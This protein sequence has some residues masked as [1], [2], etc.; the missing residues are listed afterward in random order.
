M[1]ERNAPDPEAAHPEDAGP[2]AGVLD[3]GVLDAGVRRV[4]ILTVSALAVLIAPPLYLLLDLAVVGRLGGDELAALAVA[5]LVLS[6]IST[7]L[8]FLSYGTTARSARR[9]GAGDRPGAIA[10]G[11]QASWIAVAVG[12]VIIAVAWPIAPYVMSA[13]VGDASSSSAVVAADATQWVRV[14]VFGVPLILLSMAGNGWM[15]GV[16]E[17]RRPIIYVVVGLAISAVLVVGLVHGLWFF[18]RLGIIGSAVAN[19]IGQSITGLLF[20]ARVVREQLVSVRSSAAEESGSVFAAFA[21]NRQ[22]IAAQLVMARD[23]IVRSLSFQIC[24]ISAAAVAARFGV[25]QVAAHQLVLQLWEFMSLFLDSV[26]IAAQALV[27]AAL[28]AGSVT[29]ARSVARRVTLVSVIAAAVMAAVFAAGATS[30]P[31]VFTSDT[32]VLD[33]IGVPWWFFVAMLPIAGVVFALD[34]VLLGSGDAAFLRTATLVAALVGFLPL[35]WMSL[36]FDW[37]LAGVWS[38]LVVF[39]IARLVAVCLRIASGR[40]HRVGATTPA[41]SRADQVPGGG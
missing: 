9:Y 5:T 37:G 1:T 8:T 38:G 21:P 15:R 33:A 27:G 17:T 6:I 41:G 40:W 18:P 12:L 13:L 14:A 3:A 31:K 24:F 2:D 23:L 34:G 26:A 7:Q 25:A 39:M 36:I 35:I 20:A 30:L 4:G 29:I 22:M 11:V 32:V 19:V 28:G 10:E 16:Q